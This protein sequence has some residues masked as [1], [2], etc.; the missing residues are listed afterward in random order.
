MPRSNSATFADDRFDQPH[1]RSRADS[2][3]R[4]RATTGTSPSTTPDVP[5]TATRRTYEGSRGSPGSA[6]CAGL[7]RPI[8]SR[9]G[10]PAR[11]D[12]DG[13]EPDVDLMDRVDP[14]TGGRVCWPP[15]AIAGAVT[16]FPAAT[17]AASRVAGSPQPGEPGD[18]HTHLVPPAGHRRPAG[19]RPVRDARDV[20]VRGNRHALCRRRRD[21]AADGVHRR[22]GRYGCP[23]D[24]PSCA[25]T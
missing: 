23:T 19:P 22:P 25:R 11:H 20:V 9:P 4:R 21:G 3:R 2:R 24:L 12:Q 16:A 6:P 14:Q 5:A 10:S 8:V 15:S 18:G 17:P 1:G 7:A 13:E